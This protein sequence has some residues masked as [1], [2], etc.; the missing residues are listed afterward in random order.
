MYI[1]GILMNLLLMNVE[2]LLLFLDCTTS[3]SVIVKIT[4]DTRKTKT[5]DS[6][7]Q[8]IS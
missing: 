1:G 4:D 3:V 2:A 8:A 5:A 6:K 7:Q